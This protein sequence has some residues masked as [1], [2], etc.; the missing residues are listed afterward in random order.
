MGGHLITGGKDQL[1]K[2]INKDGDERYFAL[3]FV[4]SATGYWRYLDMEVK[5]RK[6]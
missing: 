4:E 2:G 3:S 6:S 1:V 5:R